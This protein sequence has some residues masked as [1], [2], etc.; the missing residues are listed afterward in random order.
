MNDIREASKNFKTILY[1]DDP[2]L[3]SPLCSFSASTSL[4]NVQT[5]Q[6]SENINKELDNILE[7]LN[8]NKLSLNVKKTKFMIFHYRQRKI[9]SLIP[10]LKINSEPIERVTEFNFLGLTID[11][12]LSWS[13]H[14]Q[15][16]YNKISRTLGIMNRLKQFLPENILCLIYN[17]LILPYFQY[18]IFTWGFKIGRL[19]K[20]QRR[21]VRIITSSSYNAH[22]DP[23]SN[24]LSLLKVKDIFRLNVLKLHYKFRK[25]NLPVY[26]MSMFT[27]ADAAATHD[28]NL[29]MNSVLKNVTTTTS[30]GENCIRFH[31]PVSINNTE[32]S[33]FDKISTHSYEVFA[34]F[35]KRI[36]T[37]NYCT[38]CNLQNCYVHVCHTLA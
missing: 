26:T 33:I 4:K 3:I 5:E 22:T 21:A 27:Y 28:Y 11:E 38:E 25:V 18:S 31:L 13:P 20:L 23:L 17:S 1:A 24:E 15:K 32:S 36:T 29:R 14:I 7:W 34:F 2:N 19:E 12:Q 6:L 35:V 8:T 30:S 37:S 9:D 16:I 10:N